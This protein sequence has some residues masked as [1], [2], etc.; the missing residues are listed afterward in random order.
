MSRIISITYIARKDNRCRKLFAMQ[1]CGHGKILVLMF[2]HLKL[3]LIVFVV[4]FEIFQ[5][6]LVPKSVL[7]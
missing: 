4:Y 3:T 7:L 5:N 1:A 2:G 6:K